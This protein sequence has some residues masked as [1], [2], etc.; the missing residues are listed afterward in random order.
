VRLGGTWIGPVDDGKQLGVREA[1]FECRTA[2]DSA[3]VWRLTSIGA[4]QG[5]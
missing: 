2:G 3:N 1:S 4:G 5:A